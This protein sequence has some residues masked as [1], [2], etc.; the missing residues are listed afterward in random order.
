MMAAFTDARGAT[1]H[2]QDTAM[3]GEA[4]PLATGASLVPDENLDP[5]AGTA[6]SSPNKIFSPSTPKSTPLHRRF[7][8][9]VTMS[10]ATPPST[11]SRNRRRSP[12]ES[13][14]SQSKQK[15]EIGQNGF[16]F[17][18]EL[19]MR[20]VTPKKNATPT[21]DAGGGTPT[22]RTPSPL[23]N[24]SPV[25][26]RPA[27]VVFATPTKKT[28]TPKEE[29]DA[30]TPTRRTPSPLKKE[31]SIK[32]SEA[33]THFTTPKKN[34][35]LTPVRRAIESSGSPKKTIR[36]ATRFMQGISSAPTLMPP[37]PPAFFK[38]VTDEDG[39]NTKL[40]RESPTSKKVRQITTSTPS[41]IGHLIANFNSGAHKSHDGAV[42]GC[43]GETKILPA[44]TP[45]RK[46]SEKLHLGASPAFLRI[47]SKGGDGPSMAHESLGEHDQVPQPPFIKLLL[48]NGQIQREDKALDGATSA[49]VEELPPVEFPVMPKHPGKGCAISGP[50]GTQTTLHAPVSVAKPRSVAGTTR[51]EQVLHYPS[52]LFPRPEPDTKQDDKA[53]RMDKYVKWQKT[54]IPRPQASRS[55]PSS[56]HRRIGTD[57]NVFLAMKKEMNKVGA[58]MRASTGQEFLWRGPANN[59][60]LPAMSNT[61]FRADQVSKDLATLSRQKDAQTISRVNSETL[62]VGIMRASKVVN[63]QKRAGTPNETGSSRALSNPNASTSARKEKTDGFKPKTIDQTKV[64]TTR[65]KR[66]PQTRPISTVS[67]KSSKPKPPAAMT[68]RQRPVASHAPVT[69]CRT[70]PRNL[71]LRPTPSVSPSKTKAAGASPSR[72]IRKPI[73][74]SPAVI[75]AAPVSKPPVPTRKPRP[76]TSRPTTAQKAARPIGPKP[77]DPSTDPRPYED[78]FASATDIAGRVNEWKIEDRKKASI[79]ISATVLAPKTPS[80]A[81]KTLNLI[82]TDKQS[83]TPQGSPTKLPSPIKHRKPP[84]TTQ[85]PAAV[86]K[87]P[88]PKKTTATRLRDRTDLRTPVTSKIPLLDRNALR[89]PS[90]AIQCAL[91]KAIDA[92][93][94]EYARTGKEFTPSGNR[95]RDLL[96]A[97]GL[98]GP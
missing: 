20:K 42:A 98:T 21:K 32:Q 47:V 97:R 54:G 83:Y 50:T 62:S 55:E 40:H 96:E 38:H 70:G 31:G 15:L 27:N 90:K 78:K 18:F 61:V 60:E 23:K 25:K 11:P 93:I 73:L 92:K 24:E 94:A 7:L 56:Q 79:D 52:P 43:T 95:V 65:A 45:L 46:A 4:T 17:S 2:S 39:T 9:E 58:S 10:P 77:Y 57:P 16:Y 63:A 3:V 69:P 5:A 75:R 85:K 35:T 1:G 36:M 49:T 28:G 66:T 82:T 37:V 87:T 26:Q 81:D 34:G 33:G 91:D 80:K 88:Q 89:T 86:P 41:N 6:P 76:V 72:G 13:Q 51:K 68:P 71:V 14:E 84:S 22:R 29:G 30:G 19:P 12:S 8:Q 74:N 67:N 48:S 44:P 53:P 64:G 59:N